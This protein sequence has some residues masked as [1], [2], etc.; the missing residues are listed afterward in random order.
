MFVVTGVPTTKY[1]AVHNYQL[2][3]SFTLEFL[4][5]VWPEQLLDGQ[6]LF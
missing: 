2:G 6:A 1:T 4:E 3:S 5:F